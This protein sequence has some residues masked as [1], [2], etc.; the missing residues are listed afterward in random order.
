MQEGEFS[1]KRDLVWFTL[2]ISTTLS[3]HSMVLLLLRV[4]R[5]GGHSLRD[6]H[7]KRL[8]YRDRG[9]ISHF[10]Y[11]HILHSF[12][13]DSYCSYSY[14]SNSCNYSTTT[15]LGDVV[16]SLKHDVQQN[17]ANCHIV[18]PKYS[19]GSNRR[20]GSDGKQVLKD[21]GQHVTP[22]YRRRRAALPGVRSSLG[23]RFGGVYR[24]CRHASRPH[25]AASWCTAIC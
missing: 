24:G 4:T 10:T 6:S 22:R 1:E 12:R 11:W 9:M 15:T 7:R 13:C 5:L 18:K 21:R 23:S 14:H 20:R 3:T 25:G 17:R 16:V 19:M 8:A 2:Q